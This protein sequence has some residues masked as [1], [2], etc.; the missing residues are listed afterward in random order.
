M[1][2]AMT[3]QDLRFVADALIALCEKDAKRPFYGEASF[4]LKLKK[5]DQREPLV[6]HLL[7]PD[8]DDDLWRDECKSVFDQAKLTQRQYEVLCQRLDGWSFEEIGRCGGHTR[9]GA[10]SIFVQALKKIRRAYHVYPFVGISEVYR[11]EIR[12]GAKPRST[13]GRISGRGA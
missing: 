5:A 2:V 11:S 7:Q 12:R 8:N 6:G 10:Q 1:V 4:N 13:F 9:Q 3:Q